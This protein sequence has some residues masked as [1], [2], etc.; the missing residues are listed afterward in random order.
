MLKKILLISIIVSAII[1]STFGQETLEQPPFYYRYIDTTLN[2]L[3]IT[4]ANCSPGDSLIFPDTVYSNGEAYFIKKIEEYAFFSVRASCFILPNTITHI[5]NSVFNNQNHL[6]YIKLPD[7]LRSIGD[8]A[9]VYSAIRSIH[10][11]PF[12][13]SIGKTIFSCCDSL[14]T[15]TVDPNNLYYSSYDGALY[16]KEQTTLLEIPENRPNQELTMPN[17]VTR[18]EDEPV[19]TTM[20]NKI[21]LSSSLK[22]IGRWAFSY[23]RLMHE[24]EIPKSVDTIGAG[25]FIYGEIS[26]L[27]FHKPFVVD[28]VGEQNERNVFAYN[29]LDTIIYTDTVPVPINFFFSSLPLTSLFVPSKAVDA[30]TNTDHSPWSSVQRVYGD[31]HILLLDAAGGTNDTAYTVRYNAD[32]NIVLPTTQR[33]GYTFNYWKTGEDSLKITGVW[34]YLPDTTVAVAQ[35]TPINY[36]LH[37]NPGMGATVTPDSLAVTFDME[38]T[39]LPI[40]TRNGYQFKAWMVGTDTLKST[41]PWNYTSDTTAVALWEAKS[42]TLTL[43]ANNGTVTPTSMEVTFDAVIGELAS[44]SR[45][46]YTFDNWTIGSE[47]ITATTTWNYTE[48]QTAIANWTVNNYTLHFDYNTTLGTIGR[49]QQTVTYGTILDSLPIPTHNDSIFTGWMI[50]ETPIERNTVW[51]YTLTQTATARWEAKK[52]ML[53]FDATPGNATADSM[54][55]QYGEEIGTLPT[56]NRTGY[57]FSHWMINGSPISN[58]TMWKYESAMMAVAHWEAKTFTLTF[59]PNGGVVNPNSKTITYE[60]PIGEVPI[61]T[62]ANHTFLYWSYFDGTD[63][64]ILE[65][66]DT[67]RFINDITVVAKWRLICPTSMN[68]TDPING[69]NYTL[70]PINGQ[71]WFRE[72]FKGL[73]YA[74][75]TPIADAYV[76]EHPEATP[77][78]E[79]IL[80]YG[81]LY[82]WE[83]MNFTAG[84]AAPAPVPASIE[85]ITSTKLQGVCPNG[86]RIPTEQEAKALAQTYT[87]SELRSGDFWSGAD[88]EATTL[89]PFNARPA[90]FYNDAINRFEKLTVYTAFWVTPAQGEEPTIGQISCFCNEFEVVNTTARNGYSIRC[91][92][93]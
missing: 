27:I 43:N 68:F 21:T 90:G 63:S 53:Y 4:R 82:T 57:N 88:V 42:Y 69:E 38:I 56:A 28:T 76:Y 61:P 1:S 16:N 87:A 51:N 72:N 62:L 32:N 89:S 10:I 41:T 54:E 70:I 33:E 59:N 78:T 23:P 18:I 35:W 44:P 77:A 19:H 26:K 30:F 55:L 14:H 75:G 84:T 8:E 60:Q 45:N 83:A 58:T 92:Q 65:S 93:E 6:E 67:S 11:P 17:T 66:T 74:N 52:Y 12:V 49:M 50:G 31:E 22:V 86:W 36:T 46:G 40:P 79:N 20:F 85:G 34:R 81:R 37:L 80:N 13:D 2:H 25:S 29:P 7:S 9:F 64:T 24:I 5:E 39:N 91:I 3:S 47:T 15:I 48:N 73:Q 71:C